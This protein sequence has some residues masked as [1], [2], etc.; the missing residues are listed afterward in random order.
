[1]TASLTIYELL[2]QNHLSGAAISAPNQ[3]S[4]SFGDLLELTKQVIDQLNAAGIGRNDRVA[5]V[6]PNGPVMASAFIAIAAGATA[7]PLNPPD[8]SDEFRFYLSDL[9]AKALV[10]LEGNASPA[11]DVARELEIPIFPISAQLD[12]AAGLF[13]L[14]TPNMLRCR[15]PWA[16]PQ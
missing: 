10:V 1:M 4:L 12:V 3:T 16:G 11:I 8:R 7:A 14:T 5:I 13:D 2:H 9:N 15:Q 6:L